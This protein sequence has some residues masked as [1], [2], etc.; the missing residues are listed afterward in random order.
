M[1]C[2]RPPEP[3]P[4]SPYCRDTKAP[5]AA[6]LATSTRTDAPAEGHAHAGDAPAEDGARASNAHADP[7]HI[8]ARRFDADRQDEV[9]EL[10]EALDSKPSERQLLW[11]D[12]AGPMPEG[13]VTRLTHA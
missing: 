6:P 3:Q 4:T 7:E 12:I 5:G 11:I 2:A 9:L 1:W 10:D 8:R 13:L